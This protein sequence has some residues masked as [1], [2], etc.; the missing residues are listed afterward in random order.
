[1]SACV[2]L[3]AS[4]GL[5]AHPLDVWQ[6]RNPL[7]QG[8]A[9]NAVTYGNGLYVAVGDLGTILTSADGTNWSRRVSGT[10]EGLNDVVY[11]NNRFVVVG[12]FGVIAT[13]S[14]GLLWTP[15][16]GGTFS[17]LNA[18]AFGNGLYV[19]V[20][21]DNTILSS[22]D[23]AV[24][25][26][27]ASG[28]F[29]LSDVAFGNGQFVA[30]GN[31]TLTS[32]DG[33]NWFRRGSGS[34]FQAVAFG[35]GIFAAAGGGSFNP[36]SIWTSPDGIDWQLQQNVNGE[37][38]DIAYGAGHWVAVAQMSFSSQGII[39]NSDDAVTWMVANTNTEPTLAV[40]FGAGRFVAATENGGVRISTDAN[41]WVN[42][43]PE[44]LAI[45]D[46]WIDIA[47]SEGRFIANGPYTMAVS[48]D[49]IVWTNT[50]AVT[51]LD[52]NVSLR[53][54]TYGKGL[55]VAG[56][57]YRTLWVS[58]DGLTWSNPV[59]QLN[60]QPYVAE[61]NDVLYANGLFVAVGGFR[62]S[63]LTSSNGVQWKLT[64]VVTDESESVYLQSVAFGNG[65]Y[66]AV[67]NTRAAVSTN[68][69]DWASV[70]L[71]WPTYLFGI[72]FGDGGF[73]ATGPDAF[74]RSTDGT[75][76]LRGAPHDGSPKRVTFGAG[77][78]VAVTGT[79]GFGQS[80]DDLI[81]ISPDGMH[82]TRRHSNTS[83][84][85]TSV[86][87]GNGSFVAVGESGAIL[88]SDPLITLGLSIA[89][90][91][92][93]LTLSGPKDRFYDVEYGDATGQWRTLRTVFADTMP[94]LVA[95]TSATNQTR[96][97]RAALQP[98]R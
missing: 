74:W 28:P 98:G 26:S 66:V 29:Y 76:W 15:Q 1:M 69:W 34:A 14:D 10:F 27:R 42:P 44:P 4:V 45:A 37:I 64:D 71:E 9:L 6:W 35:N 48:G 53:S 94:L 81:W 79:R 39:Y 80:H 30:V 41:V 82:W 50:V 36:A 5:E 75:N 23:G 43:L 52:P 67:A 51:N 20:G 46:D 13:S 87:F 65:R 55:Y 85:L 68:G 72:A 33:L 63:I 73:V 70:S 24:W 93:T 12:N 21:Y 95:D 96:I 40:C 90:A 92:P 86:A 38:Q 19:A 60:V 2:L 8:N 97:Y 32:P 84:G 16:Y 61:M 88:Q 22:A 57:D 47:Y 17:Q 56:G 91:T 49:G 3:L 11:A 59:P 83:R 7:P 31:A 54:I 25:T 89:N 58:G 77:Y 62:G 78:F 18:V